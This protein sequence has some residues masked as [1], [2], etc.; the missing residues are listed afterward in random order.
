MPLS[1]SDVGT[2]W[3]A[4]ANV[5]SGRLTLRPDILSPSN[6]CGLV[7]HAPDVYLYKGLLFHHR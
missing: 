6:A 1:R 5:N 7:P 2:L 3:S 4:V